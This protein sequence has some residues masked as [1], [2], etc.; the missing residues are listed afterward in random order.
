[1]KNDEPELTEDAEPELLAAF[2]QLAAEKAPADFLSQVMRRAIQEP[3]FSSAEQQEPPL[4]PQT[5]GAET[6]STR[7]LRLVPRS[8]RGQLQTLITSP[9]VG[10]LAACLVLSLTAN[11]WLGN[12]FRGL[13]PLDS[14]SSV[15]AQ[16]HEMRELLATLNVQDHIT[17]FHT[18]LF[19]S[20]IETKN[21]LGQIL[22]ELPDMINPSSTLGFAATA[23]FY[24]VGTWYAEALASLASGHYEVAA[25]R[26][27]LIDTELRLL[28]IPNP[29]IGYLPDMHR[30]ILSKQYSPASLK[31]GLS[32]L[33]A[34]AEELAQGQGKES[35]TLFRVGA[36]L[37]NLRLAAV[38][39][40]KRFL[41]QAGA[42]D[43]FMNKM[44]A[45]NAPQRILGQFDQLHQI[46]QKPVLTSM[47]IE[48]ILASVMQISRLL[49]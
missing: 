33:G 39:G 5:G 17:L 8:R 43:Y 29:L 26:L 22:S 35:L 11:I 24:A 16:K 4:S 38:A 9:T 15:V 25:Q 7:F 14:N 49:G 21:N 30:A 42:T 2:Q 27:S 6:A 32:L 48:Q 44:A 13:R 41:H 20:S 40:D 18:H 3:L 28:S 47:D 19:Q 31:E 1:M 23:R 12:R 37:V 46:L 45:L 36:W 10:V 34:L